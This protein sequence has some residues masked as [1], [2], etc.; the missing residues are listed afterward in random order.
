MADHVFPEDGG[1]N[2]NLGVNQGDFDDAANFGSLRYDPNSVDFVISGMSVT[3]NGDGTLDI[4]AGEAI[5]SDGLTT[6]GQESQD[7][8]NM[9]YYVES[10]ARSNLS[11]TTGSVNYIFLSVLLT[12]DDAL[13]FVINTTDTAPNEPSL[14]IAELDDTV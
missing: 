2:S 13:E 6:A 5:V 4:S 14:K 12:D 10:D 9:A 3:D 1:T 7:R 8:R 11:F